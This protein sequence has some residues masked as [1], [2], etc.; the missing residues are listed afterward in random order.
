MTL[1][2]RIRITPYF[3]VEHV[4]RVHAD[5]FGYRGH[6]SQL[7][8]VSTSNP[9][10]DSVPNVNPSH[11]GSFSFAPI[12]FPVLVTTTAHSDERS[13]YLKP[14]TTRTVNVQSS[15]AVTERAREKIS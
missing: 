2:E 11:S 8:F 3:I 12:L 7:Y 6:I 15:S 5:R 14:G 9:A 10:L 4:V 13:R 1:S